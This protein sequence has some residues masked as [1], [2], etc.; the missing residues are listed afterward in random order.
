M[1]FFETG[2]NIYDIRTFKSY[3]DKMAVVSE[4]V[5]QHFVREALDA[6]NDVQFVACNM[7]VYMRFL[8]D[9]M[10]EVSHY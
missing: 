8:F 1:P 6:D 9:W 7:K 10:K 4:F 2:R 3:N 5:N